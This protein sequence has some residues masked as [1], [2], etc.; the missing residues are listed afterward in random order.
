MA[1]KESEIVHSGGCFCGSARYQVVGKPLL[2]AYCH[3]TLCQR[4]NAAAFIL[5]VHFSASQFSW[6]HAEPHNDV[7]DSYSVATKP[8]KVRWRCKACGCTIASHNTKLDKWS[9]W[10]AQLD[11]DEG[12]R[13]IGLETVRPTAHIFYDTRMVDIHDELGKWAG[14]ES[15]SERL[16]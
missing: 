16:S 9:I 8:W 13:I 3:C 14:Y 2:S 11:R 5:T 7:L 6:T 1:D 12:G 4:L 15:Q 10:G